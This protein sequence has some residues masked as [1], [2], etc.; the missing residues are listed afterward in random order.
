MFS[1]C[2]R[3]S[4]RALQ[5]R[6]VSPSALQEVK[7]AAAHQEKSRKQ[8]AEDNKPASTAVPQFLFGAQQ[9]MLK[10][11]KECRNEHFRK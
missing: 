4:A 5:A 7:P 3:N 2:S 11:K 10:E 9:W 6:V 8:T 1:S